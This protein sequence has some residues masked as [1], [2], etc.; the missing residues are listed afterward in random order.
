MTITLCANTDLVAVAWASTVPGLS[1][2][3]VATTLPSPPGSWA[4]TTTQVGTGFVTARTTGGTEE[5]AYGLRGPVVTFD[6][7]AYKVGSAHPQWNKACNIA[8]LIAAATRNYQQPAWGLSLPN[9][10]PPARVVGAWMVESPRRA[11]G[12]PGNYAH[13]TLS[14]QLKWVQT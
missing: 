1:S 13:Y 3:M 2:S 4:D 11:Y 12:D 10:Y 9:N 7:Y 6:C 5:P 8:E 14:V